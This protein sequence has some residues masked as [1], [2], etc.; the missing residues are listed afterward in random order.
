VEH[1]QL[2]REK[3]VNVNRVQV[4][5]AEKI[6]NLR[7]EKMIRRHLRHKRKD[8]YLDNPRFEHV[9]VRREN[10]QDGRSTS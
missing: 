8:L 3:R 5:E 4:A 9:V 1:Q 10:P 7:K 2:L 6:P